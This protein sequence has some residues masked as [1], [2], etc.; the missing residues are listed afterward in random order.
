MKKVII[1]ISLITSIFI[2]NNKVYA[3][4]SYKIGDKVTYNDIDFYVIKDSSSDSDNVTLLK[5]EPLTVDE[6]N[7]YGDNAGYGGIAYYTS[8]GCGVVNGNSIKTGCTTNYLKSE[9]KYVVDSWSQDRIK[10]GLKKARLIDFDEVA[11]LG[12]EYFDNGSVQY[13][14]KTD[15]TPSWLYN[16]YYWYWTDSSYNDSDLDMW[17][18][19][20]DGFLSHA[21]I[22]D[23]RGFV[24]RNN[25]A[26]RPVVE[27][28][29]CAIDNSC[30]NNDNK[31]DIN[32]NSEDN[33]ESE[34]EVINTNK[35]ESKTEVK[36][37][38]TLK[39]VSGLIILIGMVLVCVGLNIFII[40]KN[41][42]R[43]KD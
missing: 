1:L 4:Q 26:V 11:I 38:N 43:K 19:G 34:K 28:Y 21:Y 9:I 18:I 39:S 16:E 7:T 36:V 25:G 41:K 15:S 8:D 10:K 27:L 23:G 33:K 30:D 29:K 37:P 35:N 12:Y 40:I 20:N 14:S 42:D 24:Y 5:A 31:I 22:Y 13:Y 6:V 17:F 2:L 32:N 3:Y